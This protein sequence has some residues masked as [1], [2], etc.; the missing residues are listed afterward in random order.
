MPIVGDHP[1]TGFRVVLERPHGDDAPFEYAGFVF[2]P[3]GKH[4]ARVVVDGQGE[5]T[6]VLDDAP[7]ALR[8]KVRLLVRSICKSA[9]ADDDGAPPPRRIT[10]WRGEK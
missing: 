3:Q 9:R 5:V 6:V 4:T 8:D 2:L 7:A 10:R 1:E